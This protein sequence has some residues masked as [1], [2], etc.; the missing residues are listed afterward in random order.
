M[1]RQE[2]CNKS[3]SSR[4]HWTRANRMGWDDQTT[5]LR[6]NN[7]FTYSLDTEKRMEGGMG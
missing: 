1:I 2:A 4:T 7:K 3:T 6:S 5:G